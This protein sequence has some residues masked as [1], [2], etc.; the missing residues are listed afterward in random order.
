MD[1]FVIVSMIIGAVFI[2]AGLVVTLVNADISDRAFWIV[3]VMVSLGAALLAAGI[4]GEIEVSGDVLG[5]TVKAG[6][7]IAVFVII[8]LL[9]PPKTIEAFVNEAGPRG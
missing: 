4:L 9:N 1:A 6:G 3:R 5:L 7:P 8:Y 2:A